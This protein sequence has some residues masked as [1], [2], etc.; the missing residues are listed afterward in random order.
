MGAL[1][2]TVALGLGDAGPAYVAGALLVATGVLTGL[3]QPAPTGP[4]GPVVG[5]R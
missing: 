3:R 5:A 2:T 1:V 4:R